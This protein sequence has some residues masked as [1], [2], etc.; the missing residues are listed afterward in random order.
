MQDKKI[1]YIRTTIALSGIF[2][3]SGLIFQTLSAH[4]PENFLEG[5]RYREYLKLA[6]NMLLIESI[7]ASLLSLTAL[8]PICRPHETKIWLFASSLI[9]LGTFLFSGSLALLSFKIISPIFIT[10]LGAILQM[11]GWILPAFICISGMLRKNSL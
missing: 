3:A 11:L 4:L 1:S 7:G 2:M 9:L 5:V 8:A 6:G 10:P